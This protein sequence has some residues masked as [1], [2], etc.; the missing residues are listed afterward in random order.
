[1]REPAAVEADLRKHGIELGETHTLSRPEF[2][3]CLSDSS[4]DAPCPSINVVVYFDDTPVQ[5]RGE[6]EDP[7][8]EAVE[9]RGIG[10]WLGS[11]QGRIG[12]RS[13]FDVTFGVNNLPEA[14]AF[15]QQQLRQLGAGSSTRLVTSEGAVHDLDGPASSEGSPRC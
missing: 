10:S 5:D 14:I 2:L 13:F 15:L 3:E 8:A 11:G 4:S 12:E 6:I 1:M 9:G 7:V